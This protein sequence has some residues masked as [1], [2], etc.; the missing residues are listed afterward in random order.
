MSDASL[1]PTGGNVRYAAAI[2]NYK[3]RK[4]SHRAVIDALRFLLHYD[5]NLNKTKQN[6]TIIPLNV[7]N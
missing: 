5:I 1:L 4:R 6:K 2:Y 7:T 3:P